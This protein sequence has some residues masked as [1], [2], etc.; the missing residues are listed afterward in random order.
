MGLSSRGTAPK[1]IAIVKTVLGMEEVAASIIEE[2]IGV[3]AEAKPGGCLGLVLVLGDREGAEVVERIKK[4]VPEAEKVIPVEE[5]VG[6]DIDSIVEA[7]RKVASGRIAPDESFAVRTVRRGR[8]GY[9]SVDVNVKAG[10][11]V[12]DTTGACVNLSHPDK[13]VQV[14]ILGE[15]AAVSLLDGKGEWRK[16]RPGKPP[17]LEFI[18]RIAVA[19]IPYLG[20]PDA[21]RSMGVRVGREAQTFEVRE[22]VVTPVGMVDGSGL[23]HF[24][25]GLFEG[26]KSRFEIQRRAYGRG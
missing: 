4:E 1:P 7:A 25:N 21:A 22:L 26:V 24:L 16:L 8:R 15:H 9:T 6:S 10:A 13:I 14:E 23:R 20:P 12:K 18:R 11:A 3:K 19:H 2:A 5:W 17:V